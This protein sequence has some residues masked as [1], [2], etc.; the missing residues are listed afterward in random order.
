[1]PM[2]RLGKSGPLV[3]RIG[4]GTMSWPGCR[5]G[6]QGG[7]PPALSQIQHM[8]ETAAEAGISLVDTAEGYG[9]GL[10][11]RVLGQAL[12]ASGLREHFTIVTKT[13]PLFGNEVIHGRTCNLSRAHI[14]ERVDR[15]LERL[16]VDC[17]DVLLA[18]WPD[19]QTPVEETMEAAQDLIGSG[20]IRFFGVSNFPNDLLERALARGPVICNQ[21]PCSLADR[22]IEDGRRQFCLEQGVGIMAYS[23]LGKGILSG[24]YSADSLPPP[25]DYRHQRP[26]FRENLEKNLNLAMALREMA[27]EA[28]CPTAAVALAW[29]LLRPGITCVIPGAKTPEQIREHAES[30]RLLEMPQVRERLA[31]WD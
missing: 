11:E 29:V 24:K 8:L 2:A 27:A 20:K 16:Q 9:C 5:Y 18:H 6:E 4:L 7:N 23:P 19:P 25:D 28:G 26:H 12:R 10:A 1:M 30:V 22:S 14:F 3:S 21:L 13:G 17:V 15:A 31:A